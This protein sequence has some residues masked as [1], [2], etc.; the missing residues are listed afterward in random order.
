M[1]DGNI[2]YE[3][4]KYHFKKSKNAILEKAVQITKKFNKTSKLA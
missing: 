2:V 3:N 4:G 1:V